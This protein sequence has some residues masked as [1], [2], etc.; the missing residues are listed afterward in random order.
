MEI[1]EGLA[2]RDGTYCTAP[3]CLLYVNAA[4][5]LKPIAIQLSQT[6]GENSP[7]FLHTDAW[8]DWLMAKIYYLSSHAQ[9]FLT[10]NTLILCI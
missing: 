1:M 5:Q 10:H 2:C 9:V 6:P 4:G 3:L 7:I 8:L